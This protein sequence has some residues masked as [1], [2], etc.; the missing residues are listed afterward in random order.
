MNTVL[1]AGVRSIELGWLAG[2]M[3]AVFLAFF[4]GW[5]WWAFA[6]RNRARFEEAALL[7][8]SNGDEA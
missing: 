2:V 7:P 3:T 1:Q 8:L 6:K 4:A 5:T